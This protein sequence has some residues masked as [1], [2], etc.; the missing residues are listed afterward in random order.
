[1]A[2]ILMVEMLRAGLTKMT[3]RMYMIFTVQLTNGRGS[4][5]KQRCFLVIDAVSKIWH[6][7]LCVVL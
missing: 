2:L 3:D 4:S 6:N 1:M 5:S 7:V